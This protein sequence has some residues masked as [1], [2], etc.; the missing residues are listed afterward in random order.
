MG[1]T[2]YS[3]EDL[4]NMANELNL[5]MHDSALPHIRPVISTR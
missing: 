5:D 4:V 2:H 1:M 3:T